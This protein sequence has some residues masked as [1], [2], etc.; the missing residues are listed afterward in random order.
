M[1]EA[2]T[3]RIGCS[4]WN[5]RHWRGAFYPEKLPVKRWFDHYAETFD[6]VELNT[7]FYHLP[8][9]ETFVKW[10]DQAPAGFRYAVKAS[11]FITHAKKLKECEEPLDLFLSRARGLGEAMGPVLYQLPPRWAFNRERIEAFLALLPL[12]LVHVFEFREASWMAEEVIRLL[13]ER[14]VSY[15]THDMPG[16]DVPRHA[17]GPVAYVRFHGFAGKYWGRY[18][19]EVL[20]GWAGWMVDQARQGRDVWAY[21]NNDI[22]A[23]AIADALTLR[24][25][26]AQTAR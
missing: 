24:A 13:G 5:Y 26:V 12:D 17:V 7:S 2:G 6:T 9:P 19:D 20:I 15:C 22:H 14:G 8:K 1:T 18:P 25:M 4:G 23:D 11:R 3:I 21:F 10:K 16:M